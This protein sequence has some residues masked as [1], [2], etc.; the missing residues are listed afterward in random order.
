MKMKSY[1]ILSNFS[2]K[3]KCRRK[4]ALEEG[5]AARMDRVLGVAWMGHWFPEILIS[6][7]FSVDH[8]LAW[9]VC[10]AIPPVYLFWLL[11]VDVQC[12]VVV[13][14]QRFSQPRS[15]ALSRPSVVWATL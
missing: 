15:Y 6:I 8:D 4:L 2:P 11:R 9:V 5:D 1:A 7:L 3:G 13:L 14:A 12:G 10:E